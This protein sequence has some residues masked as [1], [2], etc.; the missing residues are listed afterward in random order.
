[1][2]VPLFGDSFTQDSVHHNSN[3]SGVSMMEQK[4]K[5]AEDI[6]LAVKSI[7]RCIH[8]DSNFPEL[9]DKLK[10]RLGESCATQVHCSTPVLLNIS[11]F[12]CSFQEWLTRIRISEQF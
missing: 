5:N 6:E 8:N 10:T 11:S 2:V 12:R 9:A 7:E 3:V 4:Q 1:M